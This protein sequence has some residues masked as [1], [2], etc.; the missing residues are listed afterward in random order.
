MLVAAT[1]RVGSQAI[2]VRIRNMSVTGAL[3]E[4]PVLPLPGTK[5]ELVRAA[6]QATGRIAW[7]DGNRCGVALDA[8]VS[9]GNWLSGKFTAHQAEIY[10]MVEQA[11]RDIKAAA[12]TV[13]QLPDPESGIGRNHATAA[14]IDTIIAS[15]GVLEDALTNDPAVV[16]AHLVELQVLDEAQQRLA[17]L[18][19][20]LA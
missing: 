18:K 19:R 9:V 20:R 13:P 2:A 14:E 12:G 3:I 7:V 11:R 16:A 6:L 1:L 17:A 15:L 10:A 8:R 5:V 4:G